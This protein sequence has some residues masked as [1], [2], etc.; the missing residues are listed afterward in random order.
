MLSTSLAAGVELKVVQEMLGHSSIVLT[1]DTYT[2]V[3]PE[4]A[5]TAT[6]KT[7][8]H[9]LKAG[10]LVPGTNRTRHRAGTKK[11]RGGKKN[12]K[13]PTRSSQ[14]HPGRQLGHPQ[15]C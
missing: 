3:L 8:A 5:R 15:R 1:A 13:N 14:A 4:V 2:S 10:R 11:R 9:V 7:A 6:E 12:R